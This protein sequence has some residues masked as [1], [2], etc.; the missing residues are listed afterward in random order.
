MLSG[1]PA[2]DTAGRKRS[3]EANPETT[4]EHF[5]KKCS[6][7]NALDGTRTMFMGSTNVKNSKNMR[8]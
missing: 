5:P 1:N 6:M 3:G 4:V 2:L 7:E 8:K